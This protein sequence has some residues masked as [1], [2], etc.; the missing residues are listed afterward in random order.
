MV[1]LICAKHSLPLPP[2]PVLEPEPSAADTSLD[3]LLD[4]PLDESQALVDLAAADDEAPTETE[5]TKEEFSAELSGATPPAFID[6][7][8]AEEA[9]ATGDVGEPDAAVGA[10][11]EA[12]AETVDELHEPHVAAEETGVVKDEEPD[13]SASVQSEQQIEALRKE[14]QERIDVLEEELNAAVVAEQFDDCDRL[15][16]EIEVLKSQLQ[17]L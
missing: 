17:F 7:E 12:E 10:D 6:D 14:L 13:E 8:A 3:Q 16:G 11:T 15:N 1:A 2:D 5:E 4:G 9:E